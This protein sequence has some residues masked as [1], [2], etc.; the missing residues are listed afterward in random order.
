RRR[1]HRGGV[2]LAR[3]RQPG[4]PGDLQPGLPLGPGDRAD[5]RRDLRRHQLLPRRAVLL[6]R[7]AHQAPRVTPV[8]S[9][10]ALARTEVMS[11]ASVGLRWRKLPP[12]LLVGG[13]LVVLV[14]LS[15]AL[16]RSGAAGTWSQCA[17][18]T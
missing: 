13:G 17:S 15:A 14:V 10:I 9:E 4:D 1:H 3:D 12:G 5:Q 2:R 6:S 7:S 18:A 16:A 8:D 11:R